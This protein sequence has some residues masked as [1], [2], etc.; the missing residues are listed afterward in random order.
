VGLAYG[1]GLRDTRVPR[2]MCRGIPGHIPTSPIYVEPPLGERRGLPGL[3]AHRPRDTRAIH[4][5]VYGAGPDRAE[6]RIESAF[7]CR[8]LPGHRLM[9]GHGLPGPCVRC[10]YHPGTEDPKTTTIKPPFPLKSPI[11]GPPVWS[12]FSGGRELSSCR[13]YGL[14]VL[15][16]PGMP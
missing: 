4:I 2:D 1:L 3:L 5:E 15:G 7:R 16:L 11:G 8:G 13:G 14:R 6:A 9:R 12:L 10:R